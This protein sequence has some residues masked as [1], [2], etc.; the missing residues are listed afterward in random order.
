MLAGAVG[1]FLVVTEG[2]V[3]GIS[4]STGEGLE[5]EFIHLLMLA[6]AVGGFVP[7]T[8]VE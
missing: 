5:H 6:G 1:G 7:V 2:C 3:P 8:V 4:L